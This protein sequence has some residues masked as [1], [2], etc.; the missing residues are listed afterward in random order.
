MWI[1]DDGQEKADKRQRTLQSTKP[2]TAFFQTRS[3]QQ[4]RNKPIR[5]R[6]S[7]SLLQFQEREL[8]E[9]QKIYGHWHPPFCAF[10]KRGQ[11]RA[12][13]KCPFVHLSKD[14]RQ[15]SSKSAPRRRQHEERKRDRKTDN[16]KG[17]CLQD[18]KID[19]PT[20]DVA[21]TFTAC[22][23]W[24]RAP[25]HGDVAD[26]KLSIAADRPPIEVPQAVAGVGGRLAQVFL[27]L[28]WCA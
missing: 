22:W 20:L 17:N 16:S 19:T 2:S 5:R 28:T 26:T 15:A 23:A 27:R 3:Q 13:V 14:D 12:G 7:T 25:E 4:D 8:P 6:R 11:C 1:Q 9:R 18:S 10:N 24:C 21:N